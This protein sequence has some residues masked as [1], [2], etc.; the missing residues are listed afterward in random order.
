LEYLEDLLSNR[1][2]ATDAKFMTSIGVPNGLT[3]MRSPIVKSVITL[4]IK[5]EF[6]ELAVFLLHLVNVSHSGCVGISRRFPMN[7]L[8]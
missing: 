5:E 8:P 1:S 2:Q 4:A 3:K 6:L 7:G